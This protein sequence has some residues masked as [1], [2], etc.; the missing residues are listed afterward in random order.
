MIEDMLRLSIILFGSE[1]ATKDSTVLDKRTSKGT[2]GCEIRD[3]NTALVS[4]RV[5]GN[6]RA[7]QTAKV[8]WAII[9]NFGTTP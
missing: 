1:G 3:A 2:K 9:I 8:P 7:N 5:P 6:K 4:I